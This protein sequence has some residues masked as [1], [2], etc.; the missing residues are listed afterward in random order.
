MRRPSS[1][2]P[3][4]P[5][6]WCAPTRTPPRVLIANSNLVPRWATWEHFRELDRKGLM[7]F[8]QMTAG[9][10]IYIGTQGILQGT[11]ETFAEAARQHFGGSLKGKWVL[12][13]GLGGM[14]GAQPLAIRMNDG[15]SLCVEIDPARIDRRIQTRYLDEWTDSLDSA[16]QR[17][18]DCLQRGEARS[19]GLLGN[20]AEVLPELLRRGA[21]PDIVTDQTSAHDEYD[22]YVPAGLS[23]EATAAL[24]HREPKRLAELALASMKDHVEAMLAFQEQGSVVFDYGNNI[25]A[26][27]QRAGCMNAFAFPGFVPAFIRPLFCRG[28]G[29]FRWVALSG[30]PEDIYATDQA[31]LDLFPDRPELARWLKAAREQVAFQGLPARICWLGAGERHLA[32]LKFNEMVRSGQLKAPIVIGRDHLD[33]G[34]VAS[35]NRETEAMKDG[36]DAVSDWPLL[37]AMT[38]SGSAGNSIAAAAP[39]G[40]VRAATTAVVTPEGTV[41]SIDGSAQVTTGGSINVVS[42]DHLDFDVIV[43]DVSAGGLAIGASIAVANIASNTASYVGS[44]AILTAGSDPTDRVRVQTGLKED[45]TGSAYAGHAGWLVLGAQ[46][47]VIN[48]SSTQQA[49]V[50]DNAQIRQAGGGLQVYA[51]GD[52]SVHPEAIGISIGSM[53]VGAA[54]TIADIGG[55]TLAEVRSAQIGQHA[56]QAVAGVDVQATGTGSATANSLGV[57]AG[58]GLFALSGTVALSTYDATVLAGIDGNTDI[59]TSGAVKVQA[60][61]TDQAG[62]EAFGVAASGLAV[63]VS[64]AQAKVAPAITARAGGTGSRIVAGDMTVLAQQLT[65]GGNSSYAAATGSTGGLIA[66]NATETMARNA[67]VIKGYVASGT[68]LGVTGSIDVRATNS[69][70]QHSDAN[71]YTVGLI[72]AGGNVATSE[73][74][75][76]TSAYLDSGVSV[77]SGEA[78]GGLVDGGLYYVVLDHVRGFT[79]ATAVTGNQIDIGA[80]HGMQTGDLVVYHGGGSANTP[81]GGLIS[82]T[83]YSVVVNPVNSNLVS[84]KYPTWLSFSA[85]SDIQDNMLLLPATHGLQ[86]GDYVVYHKTNDSATAIGGLVDGTMYQVS[87]NDVNP[88]LVA[89][90]DA[91]TGEV[92]TLDGAA[93]TSTLHS[94]EVV[95]P[96]TVAF[97]RVGSHGHRPLP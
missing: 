62:A 14:G 64:I 36:S 24:R 52:R 75:V 23:L 7:M 32:G 53:A 4:S 67:A 19:I 95:N 74:A 2:S 9:S 71:S 43:G 16:L 96:R 59:S 54:I 45:A 82:G 57:A 73:T 11:Y 91:N 70:Q 42:N 20:A 18:E 83:T 12:T 56:G 22:G 46:V 31:I 94:L 48:D 63:G 37:N 66:I 76:T 97:K 93:T 86:D 78:V 33:A 13:A 90:K 26:Q 15:V 5:W 17:V 8:G 68:S 85:T 40:A 81:V 3:A 84:L 61:S 47:V 1:S 38:A 25:R 21:K 65:D 10:W 30:D 89:L 41:A 34:S 55:T 51:T 92:I 35:P 49:V 88:R 58:I 27:A 28:I 50:Y 39:H 29:P 60:T 77:T 79:P 44:G 87:V 72:A 69:T 80:G 6:A